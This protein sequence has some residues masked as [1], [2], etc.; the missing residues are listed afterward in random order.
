MGPAAYDLASLLCDPY[1]MLRAKQQVILLEYYLE[2]APHAQSTRET[3]H[4]AA[5]QRLSQALGAFGRLAANPGTE[6]FSDHI[7]PACT[8][9]MRMLENMTGMTTLREELKLR[10]A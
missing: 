8:M 10:S 5:V 4:A 3:Y 2:R 9:M 1:V 7:Q 6:R